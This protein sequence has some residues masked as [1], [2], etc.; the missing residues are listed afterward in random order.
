M[1]TMLVHFINSRQ[2]IYIRQVM[3]LNINAPFFSPTDVV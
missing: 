1:Q 2:F 3:L